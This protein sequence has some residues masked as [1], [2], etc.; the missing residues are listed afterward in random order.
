MPA[1][2]AMPTPSMPTAAVE[3]TAV[4]PAHQRTRPSMQGAGGR[5]RCGRGYKRSTERD[6]AVRPAI[7]ALVMVFRI[8]DLHR[9]PKPRGINVANRKEFPF[10]KGSAAARAPKSD[11]DVGK[12]ARS[13]GSIAA[14]NRLGLASARPSS[15]EFLGLGCERPFAGRPLSR[16]VNAREHYDQRE[17]SVEQFIRN[18]NHCKVPR[19]RPS[20]KRGMQSS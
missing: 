11:P 10:R 7:V 18:L 16:P 6:N 1:A 17:Q 5:G 15:M 4:E 3:A 2:A 9:W 20:R 12:G 19:P 14:P 8:V 13:G